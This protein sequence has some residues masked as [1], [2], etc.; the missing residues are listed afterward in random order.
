MTSQHFNN[1]TP[2]QAELL[3]MLAEECGEVVQIVG[4][5]L[6][7]GLT[8]FHPDNPPES[9]RELL[10][11]ELDDVIAVHAMLVGSGTIRKATSDPEA[12]KYIIAKKLRYA[13]HQIETKNG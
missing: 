10:A 12:M 5:I 1:L 6:R 8:S 9:N 7:H 3:A 13:H 11:K 4:K 2:K